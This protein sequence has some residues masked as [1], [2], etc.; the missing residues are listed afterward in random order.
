MTDSPHQLR[1]RI[2]VTR[3]QSGDERA[4]EEIVSTYGPRLRYY[5][6]KQLGDPEAADDVLQDVW[7]DVY[8][9]IVRLRQPDAFRAWIYRIARDRAF[10]ALRRARVPCQLDDASDPAAL[11]VDDNSF[12]AEDA[13]RVHAALD[14]LSPWHRDVLLLRFI[15]DLPYGDIAQITGCPPGTVKSRI[16][17]A[18]RLL[19]Q[20]M[21]MERQNDHE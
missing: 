9:G 15:E 2:L 12:S 13:R 14:R 17:H 11:D 18:K 1:E 5:L 3:C 10:R 4:F 19:R 7:F 20:E 8:R 6:L 21:E 16:H